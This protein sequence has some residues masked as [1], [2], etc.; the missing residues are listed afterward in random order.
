MII[1]DKEKKKHEAKTGDSRVSITMYRTG[2]TAGV[3]GPTAFLM[4]GVKRKHGYTNDFL[5]RH[6]AAEGSSIHMTP[7]GFMTEE[8]WVELV[9]HQIK[10]IRSIPIIKANPDWKCAELLDGFGAH[11]SSVESMQLKADANIICVKEE[12]DSSHVN[13]GYDK[14]VAKTDK[15]VMRSSFDLIRRTTSICKGVVDQWSLVHVGLAAVRAVDTTVWVESFKAC[16]LNPHHRVAFPEWCQRISSD[17]EAGQQFKAPTSDDYYSMLPAFWHGMVP[18]DKK[19]VMATMAKYGGF[20]VECVRE[21]KAESHIAT[22]DLQN[23]RICVETATNF[24]EHLDLG[25]PPDATQ[26]AAPEVAA[27]E[28]AV[29]PVTH[30]WAH[31]LRAQAGGDERSSATQPYDSVCAVHLEECDS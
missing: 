4:S 12:G 2:S 25:A 23:L 15:K 18:E 24:P 21:L 22:K 3:T 10:G 6:G 14:Y 16:N 11:F 19:K 1:G 30:A 7:T 28:A 17:L 31:Q 13:Q 27:A 29:K 8:A 20:T 9:P 5:V 26:A